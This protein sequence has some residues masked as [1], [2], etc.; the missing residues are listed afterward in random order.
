MVFDELDRKI[1]QH[2]SAGTSSYEELAH[3]C[4]VTRNTVYRRISLLEE[5][6]VIKN[7][8]RCVVNLDHMDITT[9]NIGAKILQQNQDKAVS[10]LSRNKNVKLLWRTFGDH[11]LI[12]VAFCSKGCEGQT[13]Q[14]LKTVLEDLGAEHLCVS[15]GYCWEK[16][17]FSPFENTSE[18]DGIII[19]ALTPQ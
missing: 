1:I 5:K 8:L 15:V 10:L 16:A 13:I 11:N 4:N 14:E 6:G 3:Q 12:L 7:T 19:E 2:L 17:D 18:E 9:I